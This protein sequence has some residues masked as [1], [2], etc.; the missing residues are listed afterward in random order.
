MALVV[1]GKLHGGG[2]PRVAEFLTSAFQSAGLQVVAIDLAV[3]WDSSASMQLSRP[4]SWRRRTFLKQSETDG[5]VAGT[6]LSEFQAMRFLQTAQLR[7]FLESFDAV[8]VVAG[9]PAWALSV[10]NLNVPVALQVATRTL[11][12]RECHRGGARHE[13]KRMAALSAV[14]LINRLDSAG[15]RVPR[16]VFV[17]N[18][19]ML[20]WAKNVRGYAAEVLLI[21]PGI[22]THVFNPNLGPWNSEAPLI[23]V[24]RFGDPRKG[25]E[26]LVRSYAALVD[27]WSHAPDLRIVGSGE[28]SDA[29]VRATRHPAIV[30][31]ISVHSGVSDKELA[32]LLRNSSVFVAT[33]YEEGLGLAALEAMSAGLPV[34]TTSTHGSSEYVTNGVNGYLLS[35]DDFV[36]PLEFAHRVHELLNGN[37]GVAMSREARS[38]VLEKFDAQEQSKKYVEH[39][40]TLIMRNR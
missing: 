34:V 3:E 16:V 40:Q 32:N 23:T 5:L 35:Q 30:N 22:D 1:P 14:S 25:L 38:A 18:Q 9:V 12:E 8:Q 2:V 17:E 21:P 39:V 37:Q 13:S 33:P 26:R 29:E 15:I 20:Y 19:E 6:R 24:G 11:W 7:R 27:H 31:R 4:Q 10:R 36:L 28:M